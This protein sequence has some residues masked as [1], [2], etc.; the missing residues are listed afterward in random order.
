MIIT[1]PII[2]TVSYCSPRQMQDIDPVY[3]KDDWP[4][5]TLSEGAHGSWNL[6]IIPSSLFTHFLPQYLL[7]IREK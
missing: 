7:F 1:Q 4:A 5:S 3:I 6:W 2:K